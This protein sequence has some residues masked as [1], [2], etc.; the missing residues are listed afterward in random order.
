[1]MSTREAFGKAIVE[2][3]RAKENVVVVDADISKSTYTTEFHKEFPDRSFNVGV[4]EQNLILVSAG[5]ATTGKIVFASTYAVFASMRACEQV[6]TFVCYP[7]LNVKIAASHGGIQ[8][9]GDGVTHQG[10][11]D[12]AI[13]RSMPN[14]TVVHPAD[15]VATRGAVFAA[16][17]VE[18]PV[19]LRLMRNPSP[20][21]YDDGYEFKMGRG[22]VVIDDGND[23]GIIA[24]G[25]MVSESI[26]AVRILR[27]RGVRAKVI[28]ISTIKPIDEGLII[29]VAKMT[30][31][32]VTAED[33]NIIGGLG[34][35]VAEVL[36]E[37]LPTP[38]RRVGLRDVFG[39]SGDWRELFDIYGI[40]AKHIAEAC[41]D[42]IER[43]G[44]F[45]TRPHRGFNSD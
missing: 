30:G 37:N 44:R 7:G 42:A 9:G 26:E 24:T 25:I 15:A 5:L 19:Y 3:G 45:Q 22:N 28:D 12:I 31:A 29:E 8:V 16:A 40:S 23:V 33:H 11:E 13:M 20:I 18:G 10:T 27:D 17:D 41:L 4:A 39:E 32:V 34:S 6:R 43:K 2:L 1:M 35:A 14:M 38:V 36:G 21:V